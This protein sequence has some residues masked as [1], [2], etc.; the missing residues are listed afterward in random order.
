MSREAKLELP[1]SDWPIED[2]CRWEKAFKAEDRF[3]ES[4]HGADLADATRRVLKAS[5]ARFLSFLLARHPDRLALAPEERFNREIVADYL[6]WR[7][8]RRRDVALI[9][10]LHHLRGALRLIC[11]DADWSWLLTITKRIAAAMP[12]KAPRHNLVT[13]ERLYAVGIELMDR[14]VAA[15]DATGRVSKADAFAYRDGLLIA[16]LA[17]IPLRRRTLVALRIGKQLMKVGTVWELDIPPEDVKGRRPLDYPI[18]Q[19][20]SARIDLYLERFRCRIPGADQHRGVWASS[21]GRPM[22]G[23]AIYATVCQRTKA[24]LGFAVNLHRFRHAVGSFWSTHDP[25]NVSGVADILGHASFGT[26]EKHYIMAQSRLAG[27]ALQQ[28][29]DRARK[30]TAPQ[31]PVGK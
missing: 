8:K 5:Y 13:S 26:T 27:R 11:P 22:S 7:R 14:T 21:K 24:A 9:T 18:S 29:I 30:R 31:V 16:L 17:C 3:D 1:F 25:A 2:R 20:L 15:T 4:G 28:A 19:V 6:A 12:R 10:E 23:D